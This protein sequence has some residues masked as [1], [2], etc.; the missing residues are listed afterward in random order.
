MK[1]ASKTGGQLTEKPR[2]RNSEKDSKEILRKCKRIALA[3][4]K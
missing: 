3:G 2:C 4:P 1:L